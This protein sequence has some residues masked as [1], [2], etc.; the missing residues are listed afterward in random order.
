MIYDDHQ[1]SW[2]TM[3]M[4]DGYFILKNGSIADTVYHDD[5][6]IFVDER[7]M[8]QSYL[9]G[10]YDGVTEMTRIAVPASPT[11]Q[12]RGPRHKRVLRDGQV[13]RGPAR[14][15]R[16]ADNAF[17][18]PNSKAGRL[19]LQ[20]TTLAYMMSEVDRETETNSLT[21]FAHKKTTWVYS[22]ERRR[23]LPTVS[24]AYYTCSVFCATMVVQLDYSLETVQEI[25]HFFLTDNMAPE[26]Q[27][28]TRK[29]RCYCCATDIK[30]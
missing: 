12:P 5:I 25:K 2:D 7:T 1:N 13:S 17:R 30:P 29:V 26:E 28:P 6:R 9:E 15:A 21:S 11:P 19:Y 20:R 16:A 10:V 3:P 8:L 22:Y 24:V 23:A 14:W 4:S 27:R 18:N